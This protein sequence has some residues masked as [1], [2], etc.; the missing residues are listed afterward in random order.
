MENLHY[1]NGVQCLQLAHDYG[2]E[3]GQCADNFSSD[4]KNPKWRTA[5]D[6]L[7]AHVRVVTV[8]LCP[9]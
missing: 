3:N 8:A 5:S 7:N 1:L 4:F 6:K 2:K 9:Y